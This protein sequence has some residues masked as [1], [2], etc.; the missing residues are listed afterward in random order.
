MKKIY[1]AEGGDLVEMKLEMLEIDTEIIRVL[2]SKIP[3]LFEWYEK[4]IFL[5]Y[6]NNTDTSYSVEFSIY[7]PEHRM[8]SEEDDIIVY[9]KDENV[10]EDETIVKKIKEFI[11]EWVKNNKGEL[12]E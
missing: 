3:D 5:V 8:P 2:W 11:I 7:S 4:Q 9:T 1:T 12:P 10:V 6:D